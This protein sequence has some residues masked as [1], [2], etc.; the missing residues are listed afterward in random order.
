MR[1]HACRD[2]EYFLRLDCTRAPKGGK[3]IRHT[4]LATSKAPTRTSILRAQ[5]A[6]HFRVTK[7][8]ARIYA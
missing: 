8:Q 1:M 5:D 4:R 2:A 7:G 3:F 6:T